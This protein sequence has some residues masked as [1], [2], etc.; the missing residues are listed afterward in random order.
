MSIKIKYKDPLASDFSPGD[1][2]INATEG[3]LF[4]K[5]HTEL[6]K[7]QGTIV[8]GDALSEGSSSYAI[9]ASYAVSS[10]HEITYEL[11]SSNAETASYVGP[12]IVDHD[13]TINFVANEHIDHSS[14]TLTAGSG[15]TGG[16]DITANR[17]FTVGQG[18]GVTV[19]SGDV[20]IGQD[21]AT[22]AQVTFGAITSSTGIN[23]VGSIDGGDTT[24]NIISSS[25]NL[26]ILGDQNASI[27]ML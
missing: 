8:G 18:T 12:N 20:A 26:K 2:I 10:S 16:G 9:T 24:T 3:T 25:G 21:V 11:S 22:T 4:Y 27:V 17:T 6:F 7:I 5:S 23:L 13:T 19:N 14:I 1:I 15:L